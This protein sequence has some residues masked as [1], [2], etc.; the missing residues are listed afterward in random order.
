MNEEMRKNIYNKAK[1]WILDAGANI[2]KKLHD[3][4]VIDVKSD[5]NDL[6][7]TMDR[8]TEKYLAGAIKESF[9]DHHIL[10][11]E[12]YGDDLKTLDGTVWIIDPIDGTINFVHQKRNFAISIGIYHDGVG[13]IGFIYDVMADNLYS[14]KK[15]EGAYKNERKLHHLKKDK[16]L[17][18]SILGLNHRWLCENRYVDEQIMQQLIK[19]IRGSRT[20]GSA[21]LEFAFVAE[22]II[23]GYLALRLSPWDVAAGIIIVNEVDGMT[24]NEYG[25]PINLLERSLIVTANPTV[26]KE[27]I[28]SYIQKGIK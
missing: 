27:L 25:K 19:R 21:A 20:F 17:E 28:Q 7:T 6:V 22:G 16:S 12:G 2:R 4:L 5:P 24:T 14:A 1:E 18:T 15:G 9:P 26:H 10:G 23:D 8:E 13:E 11:E 3:P